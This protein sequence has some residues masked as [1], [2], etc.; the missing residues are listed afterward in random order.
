[1]PRPALTDRAIM[2]CRFGRHRLSEAPA[3]VVFGCP[4]TGVH[5]EVPRSFCQSGGGSDRTNERGTFI[6][7]ETGQESTNGSFP[8][9]QLS[10]IGESPPIPG[11]VPLL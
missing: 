1:M 2:T 3:H 10:T 9:W 8:L 5:L 6:V 7:Y 11:G 4:M